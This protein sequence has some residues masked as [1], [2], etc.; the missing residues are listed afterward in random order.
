KS[1]DKAEIDAKTRALAEASHKL[2]EKMYAQ[3]QGASA[4]G[5]AAPADEPGDKASGDGNV[6]DAEFEEVKD[7]KKKSA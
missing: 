7:N 6:V 5:S 1:D 3:A 2:A 4:Q